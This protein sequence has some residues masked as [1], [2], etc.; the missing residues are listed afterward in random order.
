VTAKA[1]ILN[2]IK[3]QEPASIFAHGLQVVAIHYT[4]SGS[5]D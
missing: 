2:R 3:V 5:T 4:R 1:A